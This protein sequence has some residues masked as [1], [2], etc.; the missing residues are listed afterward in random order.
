VTTP[1]E[2]AAYRAVAERRLSIYEAAQ[3]IKDKW[4]LGELIVRE[5]E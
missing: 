5:K 4:L 3:I 2:Q 1:K